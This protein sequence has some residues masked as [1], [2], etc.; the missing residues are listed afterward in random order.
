MGRKGGGY[1]QNT[2][3]V[4]ALLLLSPAG[5]GGE[6]ARVWWKECSAKTLARV[7]GDQAEP[8]GWTVK[9]TLSTSAD[10]DRRILTAATQGG[11]TLSAGGD[12]WSRYLVSA[13]IQLRGDGRAILSACTGTEAASGYHLQ[14][15]GE[16]DTIHIAAYSGTADLWDRKTFKYREAGS[17]P[18]YTVRM[19]TTRVDELLRDAAKARDQLS[20]DW[21]DGMPLQLYETR[22]VK[23][24]TEFRKRLAAQRSSRER[25]TRLSIEVGA[26]AVR[27]W[28]DGRLVGEE[29]EP[30]RTS[31]GVRLALPAGCRLSDLT[32]LHPPAINE[33]YLPLDMEGYCNATIT[34]QAIPGDGSRF[35]EGM[36]S[37]AP[38]VEAGGVPFRVSAAQEPRMDHVDVGESSPFESGLANDNDTYAGIDGGMTRNPAR[39]VLRIP[40]G[41]YTEALLLCA[42]DHEPDTDPVVSLRFVS[43]VYLDAQSLVPYYDDDRPPPGVA[44]EPVEIG[45][46]GGASGK[47]ARL[48]IVRI[49]LKTALLQS[50]LEMNHFRSLT[51]EI[52]KRLLFTRSYPDPGSYQAAPLG[53]K[54]GVHIFGVT[55]VESPVAMVVTTDEVGHVIA[56]PEKPSANV[57]LRNRDRRT[58]SVTLTVRT[59]DPY[60]RPETLESKV[61]VPAFSSLTKRLPLPVGV[62][63]LYQLEVAARGEGFELC[64]P[65]T[66]AYLPQDT[67]KAGWK[68]SRFG[69]WTWGAG[70][71]GYA[72]PTDSEQTARLIWKAGGRWC[73]NPPDPELYRHYGITNSYT[74][75]PWPHDLKSLPK[76]KWEERITRAMEEGIWKARRDFP[77]MDLFTLFG[78]ANIS[79]KHTYAIPPEYLGEPE[80]QL[81]EQERAKFLGWAWPEAMKSGK[82]LKA[83]R[84][85]H[86]EYGDIKMTFGNG[87][88]QFII[89][90]LKHNYPREYLGAFGFDIPFF[91]RM[92][93]R[94]PRA[95]E[96]GQMIFLLDA[97]RKYGYEDV[98]VYGTEHM[99][100]PGCPGSLT[101]REQADYYV[102]SHVVHFAM[103]MDRLS[104]VAMVF[105]TA[106][107]YG[108]CH[109]GSAG[110]LEVAPEGGG[111]GNPRESYVAYATMTRVLDGAVFKKWYPTGSFSAFCMAFSRP[112]GLPDVVTAWTLRGRRDARLLL[113]DDA[114]TRLTDA[115][116]N[117]RVVRS[118]GKVLTVPLT[119]SPVWI[120]GV[121]ADAVLKVELGAPDHSDKAPAPDAK[122]VEDFEGELAWKAEEKPYEAFATNN[123]DQPRFHCPMT[124]ALIESRD[125]R[126]K[127]MEIAMP[128]PEH[129]RRLAPWYAVF[130]PQRRIE[131]PGKP[132]K[133]GMWVKGNS[134]WGRIIFELTDAKGERWT[135]C[136]P[137]DEWNSDD[138]HSWSS[139][140]HDGWRYMEMELPTS[141]PNLMRGPAQPWWKNEG[142]PGGRNADAI[143]DYPLTITRMIVEQRTHLWYLDR[144][145]PGPE[146]RI[147]I[148]DIT[149]A[150]DDPWKDWHLA[151]NW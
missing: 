36:A 7:T 30:V 35:P 107:D 99:Y 77:E 21:V 68:E 134:G 70:T 91:E 29:R 73:L 100:Y 16:A 31:G 42:A 147:A 14:A 26:R 74:G 131:L 84:D 40:K 3:A 24:L 19:S 146:A 149:A 119:T 109:Y 1:R 50:C 124:S 85:K 57:L 2:L 72:Y 39:I 102:R 17:S 136:G 98:P 69:L 58:N 112:W 81:N 75:C 63:G 55:F 86:P 45:K 115:M 105:S 56:E 41:W 125:G 27:L 108:R 11:V 44:A 76:E 66:F 106:G 51:V 33:K 9:G 62:Y 144:I 23:E 53:C 114:E 97:M 8:P 104:A 150:Y 80:Y 78:E 110:L 88:P 122:V 10:A 120:E 52:T 43:G 20:R 34:G 83:F 123:F 130:V 93:E 13:D 92:P 59:T 90:F 37:P 38:W 79:V 6:R 142:A 141:H 117:S 133:L 15:W 12:D 60:G 61:D 67:R 151:N 127:A 111:D 28:I 103:G 135:F 87:N 65:T 137:K 95:V 118:E 145:V 82:A 126:G 49:P 18:S 71:G 121:K 101:Q 113:K 94:Q 129:E 46:M 89:E 138:I 148:D 64:K 47:R 116:G 5:L 54:S 48:W 140:N 4:L 96:A 25:W 132:T 128:K 22:R 32:V 139:V 143:V